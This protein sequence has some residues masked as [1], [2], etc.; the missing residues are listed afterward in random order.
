[1]VLLFIL[2]ILIKVA[3][4]RQSVGEAQ[5]NTVECSAEVLMLLGHSYL[6]EHV[7][8]VGLYCRCVHLLINKRPGDPET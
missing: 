7:E 1:M 8:G 4:W 5:L 6:G 3:W 2:G